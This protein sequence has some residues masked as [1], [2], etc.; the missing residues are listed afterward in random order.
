MGGHG[1]HLL[2]FY[3]WM[4]PEYLGAPRVSLSL[5]RASRADNLGGSIKNAWRMIVPSFLGKYYSIVP[6]WENFL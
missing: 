4:P 3:G 2:H 1:A 5:P 6:H